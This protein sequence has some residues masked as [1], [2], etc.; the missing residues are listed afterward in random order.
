MLRP[1]QPADVP[2]SARIPTAAGS[3]R[4][5]RHRRV[6]GLALRRRRL[7]R[8][9]C[10]NL[11]MQMSGRNERRRDPRMYFNFT[12]DNEDF[13]QSRFRMSGRR[14]VHHY[15]RRVRVSTRLRPEPEN[16]KL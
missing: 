10:R 2:M 6:Q 13:L 1:E 14:N 3:T 16:R 11:Q 12:G 15:Q 9:L 4:L 5:H 8:K 7:L